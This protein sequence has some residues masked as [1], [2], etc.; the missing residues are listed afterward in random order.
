MSV[1]LVAD[2]GCD[3]PEDPSIRPCSEIVPL[4]IQVP[5][6]GEFIDDIKLDTVALANKINS[7]KLVSHSACPSVEDYAKIMEA[8]DET[9]IITLSSELS[10]SFNSAR[11]AK[12]MVLEKNPDKKICVLDSKSASAGELSI[13]L[14]LSKLIGENATFDVIVEKG[15]SYIS[16]MRTLFVLEDISNLVKNGRMSKVKGTIAS[17]LSIHPILSDNGNGEIVSYKIVRGLRNSLSELV[18]V[19]ALQSAKAATKSLTLTLSHCNCKE[20]A[21][22]MRIAIL[23]KCAS[24]GEVIISRTLGLSTLYANN[25]GIIAAFSL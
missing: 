6:C 7:Q 15:K 5:D 14:F 21:E 10:G 24:V 16:K 9:V 22:E 8:H 23:S 18:E 12:N 4:K 2:S 17:V 1:Y 19:I 3:L 25:G 11:V 13:A 20:R